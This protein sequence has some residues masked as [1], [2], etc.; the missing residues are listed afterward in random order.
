MFWMIR[1]HDERRVAARRC[2]LTDPFA[3]VWGGAARSV[4]L[5]LIVLL[6]SCAAPVYEDPIGVI[7]NREMEL[8]R[9]RSA[10]EQAHERFYD[11]PRRIEA[12]NRII[13][14]RGHSNQLR[15]L[16][17]DE[18]LEYDEADFKAKAAKRMSLLAGWEPIEHIYDEAVKRGWRDF[19]P[20]VVRQYA[21]PAAGIADRDRVERKVI[22]ALNPGKSVEQVVFEVFAD[23][24]DRVPVD[25]QVG[26]WALLCR[27]TPTEQLLR[28]IRRAPP[29][30]P[31]VVDLQACVRDLHTYPHN[32]EGVLWLAYL[33]DPGQREYWQAARDAVARLNDEQRR[34]LELRHLAALT[35]LDAAT[36]GMSRAQLV[37][38]VEALLRGGEHHLN[39]PTY[40]GPMREYS[41]RFGH[42]R[43]DLSW[44][45]LAVMNLL[46]GSMHDA[47]MTGELFR[48]ADKDLKDVSTEYGGVI[49]VKGGRFIARL[50]PPL[51]RKHDLKFIPRQEMVTHLYTA[52]A[53]YHFHAQSYRNDDYA[54]PGIGDLKLADSLNPNC[55]VFTFI[56]RDRLNVD[57]Y[58]PGGVVIDLGTIRR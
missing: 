24:D 46:I 40:D 8:S 22:E 12:L 20:V 14:E 49:D 27:L 57:Y 35:H 2:F 21:R 55:L 36:L 13:W 47:A 53:H 6:T 51:V 48:Q 3:W 17:I 15:I 29:R 34:G 58:Q 10:I 43:D 5:V 1:T 41:Q 33:R 23:A 37:R 56:D 31:L 25:Q 18:L 4:S 11:D 7:G 38:R 52:L 42:W 26:A 39:G 16:A 54:G 28:M 19:T 50:Y 44:G 9:R 30:T 45:D 32:R